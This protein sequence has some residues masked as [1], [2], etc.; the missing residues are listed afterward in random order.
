MQ[1]WTR[2]PGNTAVIS[3]GQPSRWSTTAI[4]TSSTP[5][6]SSSFSRGPREA[7]FA[8]WHH[9]KPELG[10]FG[11]F[12]PQAQELLAAAGADAERQMDRL[13]ADR[14]LVTDLH[15]QGVE[16]DHRRPRHRDAP[17]C[18]VRDP[19]RTG[20]REATIRDNNRPVWSVR[21]GKTPCPAVSQA[22]S[23]PLLTIKAGQHHGGSR[24]LSA[25]KIS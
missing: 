16:D 19:S 20:V 8:G 15:L 17:P 21:N 9:A 18:L 13:V 25:I 2:A 24:R 22:P 4:N 14:A 7:G 12:D 11:L 3:S 6:F 23:T 1:V 10:A 5:R